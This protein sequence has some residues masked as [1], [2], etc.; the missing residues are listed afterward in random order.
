MADGEQA[1]SVG[2]V[3]P[4][5]PFL[6]LAL[7]GSLRRRTI[8]PPTAFAPPPPRTSVEERWTIR[9]ATMKKR[10]GPLLAVLAVLA[11]VGF[12]DPN[13][14]PYLRLSFLKRLLNAKQNPFDNESDSPLAGDQRFGVK[15]SQRETIQRL[16]ETRCDRDGIE[17]ILDHNNRIGLLSLAF[18]KAMSKSTLI[19]EP[20]KGSDLEEC[21]D[22]DFSRGM[23]TLR[24]AFAYN[25]TCV[26][27]EYSQTNSSGSS[28]NGSNVTYQMKVALQP[29]TNDS[30]VNQR[31]TFDLRCVL[32]DKRRDPR[33]EHYIYLYKSKTERTPV[34]CMQEAELGTTMFIQGKAKSSW[35]SGSNIHSYPMN[36]WVNQESGAFAKRIYFMKH[37]CPASS[38]RG[39]GLCRVHHFNDDSPKI[40]L[41]LNKNLIPHFSE[42]SNQSMTISC[43]FFPCSLE[44]T[45]FLWLVPKC[46]PFHACT[47][48]TLTNG[49]RITVTMTK[50]A[51]VQSV[52]LALVAPRKTKTYDEE[53]GDDYSIQCMQ[54]DR[55]DH[56]NAAV[57]EEPGVN[58]YVAIGVMLISFF[59]GMAVT[60]ILWLRRA[61]QGRER[62]RELSSVLSDVQCNCPKEQAA[63]TLRQS[64][65]NSCAAQQVQESLLPVLL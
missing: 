18:E 8:V 41:E 31:Y 54:K 11:V 9:K 47:G 65:S 24:L 64:E 57:Q 7:P 50:V 44:P 10:V 33:V 26:K 58:G 36:C 56:S 49:S 51:V 60:G 1:R 35:Y 14:Q 38:P 22:V 40:G 19:L 43:E 27:R 28:A 46:P 4:F 6:H 55:R 42:Q 23:D 53:D 59:A 5:F 52:R 37:G 17:I 13:R 34:S 62:K 30:V 32:P 61:R 12:S 3:G 15:F 16:L 45:E 39:Y 63:A 29:H 25:N 48:E 20:T 2:C 21:Q